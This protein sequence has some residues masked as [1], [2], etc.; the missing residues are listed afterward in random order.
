MIDYN[1]LIKLAEQVKAMADNDICLYFS[2]RVYNTHKDEI[3]K[4]P[5]STKIFLH[6]VNYGLFL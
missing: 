3:S 6:F 4:L 1:K 5:Y 2:E